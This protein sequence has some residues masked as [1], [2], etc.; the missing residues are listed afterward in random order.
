MRCS[1]LHTHEAVKT[2]S[3][4][5]HF[6][7]VCLID[8]LFVCECAAF[9][10]L[11]IYFYYFIAFILCVEYEAW[12]FVLLCKMK[13]LFEV[14]VIHVLRVI[15]TNL[16]NMGNFSHVSIPLAVHILTV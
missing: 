16:M 15:S 1:L 11:F 14:S 7:R 10:H 3:D 6:F 5:E 9:V 12:R 13:D 8:I 2:T 4:Q